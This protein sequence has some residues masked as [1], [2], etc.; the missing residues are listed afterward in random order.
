MAY[1]AMNFMP[2]QDQFGSGLDGLTPADPT[3][4]GGNGPELNFAIPG[5]FE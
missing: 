1:N 3:G 2:P 5:F 4:A